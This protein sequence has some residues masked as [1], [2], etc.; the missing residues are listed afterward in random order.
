M[1]VI[2]REGVRTGELLLSEGNG[3]ISRE[4]VNIMPGEA[5]PSG[6]LLSW[7][8]MA[9]AYMPVT[10][11]TT[12]DA[13]LYTPVAESDETRTGVA[14]VRLAEVSV[15]LLTGGKDEDGQL[16]A[17]AKQSLAEKLIIVR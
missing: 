13:V 5:L 6:Q 7:Y 16:T 11:D 17:E 15:E 10:E 9:S 4:Q 8:A 1:S 12:A 3:V 2:Q 14:I